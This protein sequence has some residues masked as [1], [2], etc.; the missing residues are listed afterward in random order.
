MANADDSTTGCFSAWKYKHFTFLRIK[1]EINNYDGME[2]WCVRAHIVSAPQPHVCVSDNSVIV[3]ICV[4]VCVCVQC[5]VCVW[6]N[7]SSDTFTR[8]CKEGEGVCR[9]VEKSVEYMWPAT[10]FLP[11][12]CVVCG[13]VHMWPASDYLPGN[14]T[15][16]ITSQIGRHVA[17]KIWT[18]S[19]HFL[20]SVSSC[21]HL[22]RF[23]FALFD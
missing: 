20:K 3:C 16:K 15:L 17:P 13:A 1:D 4:C 18:R 19:S 8:H 6:P 22:P 21:T 2:N 23:H 9:N 14:P 11:V 7:I 12:W 5:N 10:D